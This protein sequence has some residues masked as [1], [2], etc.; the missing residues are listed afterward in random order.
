MKF[1]IDDLEKILKD[2]KVSQNYYNNTE[3]VN[4][5]LKLN[6]FISFPYELRDVQKKII[7]NSITRII[8]NNIDLLHLSLGTGAG[9]SIISVAIIFILKKLEF[10][11]LSDKVYIISNRNNLL[12][13]YQQIFNFIISV[14]GIKNYK[15][16][17]DEQHIN[18][19]TLCKK[20]QGGMQKCIFSDQCNFAQTM[21]NYKDYMF[22][23]T[24]YNFLFLNIFNS[25]LKRKIYILDEIQHLEIILTELLFI[26]PFKKIASLIN[27]FKEY[28]TTSLN[29]DELSFYD[30]KDLIIYLDDLLDSLYSKNIS[31]SYIYKK[32]EELSISIGALDCILRIREKYSDILE[33][34]ELN[35]FEKFKDVFED[36]FITDKFTISMS[37]TVSREYMEKYI[38]NN[39]SEF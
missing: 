28:H 17:I 9:K 13:Q 32:Y 3:S 12:D 23:A 27:Y 36:L 33:N 14:K 10:L 16:K 30:R 37:A 21:L 2:F 26:S 19:N 1:T 7:L 22:L 6:K 38:V 34:S 20:S 11:K 39:K 24:N 15:C 35:I 29:L 8:N 4:T 25:E 18:I 31:S 5:F